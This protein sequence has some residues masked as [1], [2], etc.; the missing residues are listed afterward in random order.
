MDTIQEL[1]KPRYEVIAPYPHMN[2]DN[3]VVGDII[4][5]YVAGFMYPDRMKEF[6]DQYPH[7]FKKLEWWERREEREMP[8]YVKIEKYN[9][10]YKVREH[11]C[12]YWGKPNQN[13]CHIERE[14]WAV[15][16][17]SVLTP[18]TL[19]DFNNQNK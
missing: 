17:Y 15:F 18:A 12:G 1:L 11:F 5:P 3:H 2:L 8:E 6:Y 16:A 4:S 10:V 13:E 19:E 14:E 9:E 7:L